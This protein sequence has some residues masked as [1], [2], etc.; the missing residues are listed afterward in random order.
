MPVGLALNFIIND[1]QAVIPMS[2]EEPSVIA[3]VS[4]AAKT[5]ASYG[6]FKATAPVRNIIYS[7]VVL[8]DIGVREVDIVCDFAFL[9]Y[10]LR[11]FVFSSSSLHQ[12]TNHHRLNQKKNPSSK[13]QTH[14]APT[15]LQEVVVFKTCL[16]VSFKVA[17]LHNLSQLMA[18]QYLKNLVAE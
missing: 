16:S 11:R 6:G 5:I 4:G 18:N 7:Q 3:A 15:W 17:Y 14:S 8:H 2:V 12:H 1:N 13:W 9:F 10:Y